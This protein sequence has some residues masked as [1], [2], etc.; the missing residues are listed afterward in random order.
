[1]KKYTHTE[2]VNKV[3][4]VI[5][6]GDDPEKAHDMEDKLHLEL[7]DQFCPGWVKAEIQRLSDADFSRW[8]A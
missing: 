7:I 8:C 2:L 4:S 3:D 1:M 5:A 6:C